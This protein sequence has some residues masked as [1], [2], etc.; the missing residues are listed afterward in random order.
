[1]ANTAKDEQDPVLNPG[2]R[3][4]QPQ[5]DTEKSKQIAVDSPDITGDQIVVPTY[6][7][8]VKPDG[9]HKQLH[10]IK[11]A[12]EI[13]DVIRQMRMDEDGNRTWR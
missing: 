4:D 10:H 3:A 5:S 12:E 8:E 2:D 7:E 13:S 6:F 11:D 1:M 9:E